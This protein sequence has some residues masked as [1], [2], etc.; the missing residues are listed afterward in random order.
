M[1]C[2]GFH[3]KVP[4]RNF[5]ISTFISYIMLY[6]VISICKAESGVLVAQHRGGGQDQGGPLLEHAIV[7]KASRKGRRLGDAD[8][9]AFHW[10]QDF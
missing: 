4:H 9:W 6:H 7:Q 5:H 2:N 3:Q 1:E 10:F 8:F